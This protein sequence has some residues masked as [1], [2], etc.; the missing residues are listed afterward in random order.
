MI[1]IPSRF[2][3]VENAK[4][5]GGV[6]AGAGVGRGVRARVGQGRGWGQRGWG[7]GAC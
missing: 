5:K 4:C 6:E 2:K 1:Q 3:V 7:G